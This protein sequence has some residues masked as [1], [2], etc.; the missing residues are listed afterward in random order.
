MFQLFW[1]FSNKT[2]N[3]ETS[4]ISWSWEEWTTAKSFNTRR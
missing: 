1:C 3:S 2:N 4:D